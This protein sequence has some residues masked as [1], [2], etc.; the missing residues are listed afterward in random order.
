[1]LHYSEGNI[2]FDSHIGYHIIDQVIVSSCVF[3][4]VFAKLA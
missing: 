2:W 3:C 1:M 4:E